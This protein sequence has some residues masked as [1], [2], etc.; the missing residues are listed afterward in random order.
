MRGQPSE[1]FNVRSSYVVALHALFVFFPAFGLLK[2]LGS[3]SS[4]PRVEHVGGDADGTAAA[5]L[6]THMDVVG[7]EAL[8]QLVTNGAPTAR[9]ASIRTIRSES[10]R[11][12]GRGGRRDA[13]RTSAAAAAAAA[14]AR[15]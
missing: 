4:L 12:G 3:E 9:A 8:G 1:G 13:T 5:R 10:K 7:V 2:R 6:M 11:G 14:R 15:L